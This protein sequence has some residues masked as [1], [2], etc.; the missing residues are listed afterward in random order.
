MSNKID[1][2]IVAETL[3]QHKV[4]PPDV[5]A[6]LEDLNAKLAQEDAGKED[7]TPRQ[8]TQY[9]VVSTEPSTAWVVQI[10]EMDG[11]HT[12]FDRINQAAHAFNASKRGK[13]IPVKSVAEALETV[14]RKQMKEAG[15]LKVC[16][17][18]PVAVITGPNKLSEPPTA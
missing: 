9:V 16:T 2:S 8:K 5:R 12:V 10:A 7:P 3:K 1:L 15:I 6:I 17:K 11:P 18:I 4:A 14:K 13:L